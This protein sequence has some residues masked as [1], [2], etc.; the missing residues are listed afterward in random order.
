ME[1]IIIIKRN[2][3]GEEIW[4]YYGQLVERGNDH[5]VIE[6][7][8]D[9]EDMDFH[10]MCLCKGDRFFETYYF[11][12][13]YNI[14]EIFDRSDGR[15]KGWYCNVSSPAIERGGELSYRDFALDLMVFPDGRQIVL[16]EDEFKVLRLSP[17]EHKL[18]LAALTELQ[19]NFVEKFK[20]AQKPP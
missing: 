2:P 16:D 14:F 7:F 19:A 4:R 15:L 8:F 1:D 10:G 12:R 5:L 6:A 9:R 13:W 11:D 18:A 3:Q 17:K 20:A